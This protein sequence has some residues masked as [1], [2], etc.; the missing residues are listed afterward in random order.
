MFFVLKITPFKKPMKKKETKRRRIF[1]R[2][3]AALLLGASLFNL[4]GMLSRKR[5]AVFSQRYRNLRKREKEELAGDVKKLGEMAEKEARAAVKEELA[6][7]KEEE[8]LWQKT[9]QQEESSRVA[10]LTR[11][12]VVSGWFVIMGLF[13]TSVFW[14]FPVSLG[15][16]FLSLCLESPIWRF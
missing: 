10:T 6:W 11:Y 1:T 15:K 8:S 4:G 5:D 3:G 14:G 9:E 7:L 13:V 2:I 12:M 16:M